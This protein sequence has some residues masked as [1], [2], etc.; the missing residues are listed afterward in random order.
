MIHDVLGKTD[1]ESARSRTTWPKL[2]RRLEI[3]QETSA[4]T[5]AKVSQ[6]VSA[7]YRSWLKPVAV[8]L[9]LASMIPLAGGM[10]AL[11]GI[12]FSSLHAQVDPMT[13]MDQI[14][15]L[16][17]QKLD[18]IDDSLIQEEIIIMTL[19]RHS[20]VNE[21]VLQELEIFRPVTISLLKAV[22]D[23]NSVPLHSSDTASVRLNSPV[24]EACD[25]SS[26]GIDVEIYTHEK[27]QFE[28]LL[29][30]CDALRQENTKLK[31]LRL[32]LEAE[33]SES[34][35]KRKNAVVM[36]DQQERQEG[37]SFWAML[38]DWLK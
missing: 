35:E 11:L 18:V 23:E 24:V 2:E 27:R 36:I 22:R 7:E 12:T 31:T 14:R 32:E 26:V 17:C 6:A 10:Q 33:I 15:T 1:L 20:Q 38:M 5:F 29:S 16:V 28:K 4:S 19:Q 8:G 30:E 9:G 25:V 3:V 34:K 37:K 21:E 13:R